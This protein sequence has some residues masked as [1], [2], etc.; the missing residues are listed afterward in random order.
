MQVQQP[1]IWLSASFFSFYF[2]VVE[3]MDQETA[4]LLINIR[5]F[6]YVLIDYSIL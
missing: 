2:N 5:D 1:I 6:K 4:T 3:F